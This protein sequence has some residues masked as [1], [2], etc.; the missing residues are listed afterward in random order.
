LRSFCLSDR[1]VSGLSRN[2]VWYGNLC[3]DAKDI[4]AMLLPQSPMAKMD[5]IEK[6]VYV[7][8]PGRSFGHDE[9]L[10]KDAVTAG[11]SLLQDE[12]K[13]PL[14]DF[15]CNIHQ[16]QRK[17]LT[18]SCGWQHSLATL[19]PDLTQDGVLEDRRNE[20]MVLE[21]DPDD[22]QSASHSDIE[23]L[24]DEDSELEE[25]GE[26]GERGKDRQELC[27][28]DV[29]LEYVTDAESSDNDG[30]DTEDDN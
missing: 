3:E 15:N 14:A 9:P 10:A 30:M 1:W 21:I 19:Q 4:G 29:E 13:S 18:K 22:K 11:S 7:Y 27:T 2:L 16:L 5:M 8:Q 23:E 28:R 24:E 12:R 25:E 20:P 17:R 26:D 6:K